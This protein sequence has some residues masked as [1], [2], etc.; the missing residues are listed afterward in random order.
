MRSVQ[1]L[2]AAVALSLLA[3]SSIALAAE[4]KQ[5]GIFRIYHRDS[6]GSAS[7]HEG[8]TYSVNIAFMPVSS[9]IALD[10]GLARRRLLLPTARSSRRTT[11]GGGKFRVTDLVGFR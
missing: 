7:I 4:P 2:A 10:R 8:A 6:P 5:G 11:S 3:V 1:A 9:P